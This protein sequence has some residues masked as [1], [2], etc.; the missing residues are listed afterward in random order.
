[1]IRV[2]CDF[3]GGNILVD[4]IEGDQIVVHQDLR[5]T[6]T[7]WFYW[8][9]RVRG[10][11][12]RRITVTFSH[13]NVIG[14]R[15]AGM[16]IDGG[17]RWRWL[18]A[19]SVTGQSFSCQ[20]PAG[21]DDARFSF[22]MPYLQANLDRFL[23]TQVGNAH[24]EVGELCK[25]NKGRSV[26]RLRL[27]RLDGAAAHKILLTCR[28]HCCEMMAS[29]SLEGILQSILDE[30]ETGAWFRE[31]VEVMAVPFVDKDGVEDG[32]QGK[33][34]APRD[35]NRDYSGESIHPT[36]RTLRE[37]VPA[38]S[39]NRLRVALDMHCP[40][41][42]GAHNEDIYFPGGPD[43]SNWAQVLRFSKTIER[44]QAGPL[45][46]DAQHN[47]PYGVAWNVPANGVQG[48]SFG[49]WSVGLAGIKMAASIEI[50]YANASGR[51]V[52]QDTAR[53]FGHDLAAALRAYLQ[54]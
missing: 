43:L 13:S 30:S 6:T 23:Q 24:L 21:V 46:F 11:A 39:E 12:G 15:G 3:P 34:R 27:G 37:L 33:N 28:H 42:R 54:D 16:S 51:E 22:G 50:P 2:D 31:N 17:L 52:N 45:V 32:D 26:E 53:A 20:I 29:Y 48:L 1:M 47:L 4:S 9:F 44:V 7:D 18:G 25:T 35:H 10:A 40:H 8:Y 36:T 19:E 41:I 5:D 49:G 38:W 14:V